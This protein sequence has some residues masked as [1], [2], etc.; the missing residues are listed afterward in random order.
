MPS[1]AS[2]A[3]PILFGDFRRALFIVSKPDGLKIMADPYT[4]M[5]SGIVRY[6]A[7]LRVGAGLVQ[8]E[9]IRALKVASS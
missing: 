4:L 2:N 8:P 3:L 7:R 6:L 9:A 1:I 5:G